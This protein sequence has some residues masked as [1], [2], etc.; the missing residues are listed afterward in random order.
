MSE[1]NGEYLTRTGG[2][3]SS[4]N[5]S[6]YCISHHTNRYY[7][8]SPHF[9]L[10]FR[11]PIITCHVLIM[12]IFAI[13][14]QFNKVIFNL[15]VWLLRFRPFADYVIV[16]WFFVMTFQISDRARLSWSGQ[17]YIC[18]MLIDKIQTNLLNSIQL[19]PF[20]CGYI[21]DCTQLYCLRD[22]H[23]INQVISRGN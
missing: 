21:L 23:N 12:N 22:I 11:F 4:W 5:S 18:E 6:T 2:I 19:T 20:C 1:Q 15:T 3:N 8:N 13:L 16:F 14:S 17:A 10:N 7:V 9:Q